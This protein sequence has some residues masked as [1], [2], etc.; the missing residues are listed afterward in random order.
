M[1]SF[2]SP[3]EAASVLAS[4]DTCLSLHKQ[5]HA[6]WI[7]SRPQNAPG[8]HPCMS[9]G[10][11]LWSLG[12]YSG[13]CSPGSWNLENGKSRRGARLRGAHAHQSVPQGEAAGLFPAF[14]VHLILLSVLLGAP[15]HLSEKSLLVV[16]WLEPVSAAC[17]EK[18]YLG[19]VVTS[20][21]AQVPSS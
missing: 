5:T 20:F 9:R 8:S 21:S 13:F 6:G 3:A 7:L 11:F 1:R 16:C 2:E 12:G 18:S 10:L 19:H 14:G 15:S 4:A 17:N